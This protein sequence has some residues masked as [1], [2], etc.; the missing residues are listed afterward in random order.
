MKKK[1]R[2]SKEKFIILILLITILLMVS[3][4]IGGETSLYVLFL[5]L[6]ILSG[7]Y[8]FLISHFY[9]LKGKGKLLKKF[10]FFVNVILVSGLFAGVMVVVCGEFYSRKIYVVYYALIYM[11]TILVLFPEDL[12]YGD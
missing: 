4:S 2:E 11:V 10:L 8:Y 1:L 7:T 12:V 6:F 9:L 3:S 5:P